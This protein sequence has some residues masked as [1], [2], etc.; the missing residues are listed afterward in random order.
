MQH[1]PR[2]FPN[3][4]YMPDKWPE[5]TVVHAEFCNGTSGQYQ[6]KQLRWKPWPSGE[7]PGDVVRFWR[8]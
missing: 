7:H 5:E 3:P 2:R 4:G 6:L 1:E 8:A